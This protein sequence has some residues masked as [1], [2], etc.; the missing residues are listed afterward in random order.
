[1]KLTKRKITPIKRTFYLVQR[2]HR[3]PWVDSKPF[4]DR[5]GSKVKSNPFGY[6]RLGDYELDYMGAAEFEFGAIPKANNRL[7]EAGKDLRLGQHEY[8]GFLFDFLWIGREGEPF[9]D[10]D[11]WARGEKR[12]PFY[13]HETPY[14]LLQVVDEGKPISECRT[15]VWWSLNDNVQ[16]AFAGAEDQ[17]HL[18]KMLAS[19]G[20]GAG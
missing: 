10:F 19:M 18:I 1:M 6:G 20:G 13:G 15:A 11:R 4:Y 17:G 16:F 14:E 5:L 12:R 2:I 8:K 9:D 3:Q 7:A